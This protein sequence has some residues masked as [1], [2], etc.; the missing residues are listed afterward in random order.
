MFRGTQL[1]LDYKVIQ[2]EA[3][4]VKKNVINNKYLISWSDVM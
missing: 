1:N 2:N 3:Q 4:N